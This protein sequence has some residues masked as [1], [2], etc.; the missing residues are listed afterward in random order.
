MNIT[1]PRKELLRILTAVG[2]IAKSKSTLPIVACVLLVAK[3]GRLT[4]NATDIT[5]GMTLS[6]A[7]D[8]ARGGAVAVDA[9]AMLERSKT[10]AEGPVSLSLDGNKMTIK[11]AGSARK[12]TLQTA[13]ADD[14]PPM[15]EP[16]EGAA[17]ITI[18]ASTLL[19]VIAR[20]SYA[21][22][23]DEQRPNMSSLFLAFSPGKLRGYATDAHK[24]ARYEAP[25]EGVPTMTMM[26]HLKSVGEIRR[27]LEGVSESQVKIVQSGADAFF[28]VGDARYSTKLVDATP[29]PYEDIIKVG[30]GYTNRV[31]VQ[32]GA[33]LEA[34][35]AIVVAADEKVGGILFNV[36]TTSIGISSES[37]SGGQASD[38]VPASLDGKELAVAMSGKYIVETLASM[39]GD[40]VLLSLG[41]ELDPIFLSSADS[42]DFLGIIM[43]MRI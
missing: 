2:G 21:I 20:T 4:A 27:F 43:P 17:Q 16:N 40:E 39:T 19:T 22:C 7:A 3:D 10:L 30:P 33:L 25:V 13:S 37:A 26:V 23:T 8:V 34:C 18:P 15:S 9:K 5:Q 42:Q 6:C 41:G 38:N 12:F 36:G 29:P 32:R 24:M 1:L 11:G 14:F 31:T 35:R 28:S